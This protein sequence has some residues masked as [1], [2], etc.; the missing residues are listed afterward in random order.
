MEKQTRS[1][2]QHRMNQTRKQANHPVLDVFLKLRYL[3]GLLVIVVVVTF[4]LNGSSLG[5]WDTYVSQR[6]DG[7]KSDVIFGENREVRSDEWLVQTPF[8]LS[9][10]EKGYPL[11]NEDYSL[12]GQNMIIAY[13]SPV[14]D[15]TVIGKPFNWGFF[16]LGRDR[17]LSFYWAMKLVVMV[18][19]GFELLMILTK[20]NKGL[21]LIGSFALAFSPAVQWWF[22]QHVG[23]L[24]FFTMGLMVAFYHYFYQHDKKWLRT[25]MM[26]LVMIFG[27]GFILVIYPAHQVMLAYLLVFY[28][29]GV[30]IYFRNKITWDLF[31]GILITAA[32]LFI[33]VVMLHFWSTSKDALM[34]S[35]NTLYPGNRI[36][37]GGKWHIGEFFYFLTNWKISFEDINFSNN[38]EVALFYHFFPT[39]FLASPFVLF[40][41]KDREQ[42]IIGRILMIF[43]LFAI[44]WITVGLPK[45]FAQLTLLSFVPPFRAILTFSFAACLLTF[46]F[47]AYIW[48]HDV[49][50]TW[51]KFI[52]LVANAGLYFY[53]L[54]NSKMENYFS[55]FEI[56]GIVVLGTILLA[57]ALFRRK[58]LF[59]LALTVLVIASGFFVNPV[60]EG[61]GAI[62][63]KSLAKEIQKIDQK[64]PDQVWL[65]E[66]EIYNFTPTLGVKSFNTV[67]FYP[68]MD[69]WELI[70]PDGKYEKFYNRYAHTRAFIAKE[71]TAFKLDRPDMFSVTLNFE[72][73]EKLGIKYVVSKRPLDDYNQLNEAQFKQLY[74]PDK[75]G[76][77]IFEVTYPEYPNWQTQLTGQ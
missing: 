18:L 64:D 76:Y 23:D 29:I 68:D 5:V 17:G 13:N 58:V 39:V 54:Q 41:K 33:S 66:D 71:E 26:L 42:K 45:G 31:D 10:A 61:T 25:L 62:F 38:S 28:F 65:S 60:V 6:D 40:G 69:A 16:F 1:G 9:Q 2:Q 20:K 50:P 22:M 57:F 75:D 44:F 32:V 63:E 51:Y 55:E 35:I 47:I 4:N 15:I 30:L 48:Q 12:N 14:K 37:T 72:D 77:M 46:W 11:V 70:D 52:L 8:Y 3:I 49:I 19:L 21:S 43:C 73:A 24:I 7:K 27:I 74:G 56:I 53:A 36:S 34:A 59:Y 67:R